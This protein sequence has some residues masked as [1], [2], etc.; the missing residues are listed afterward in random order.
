MVNQNVSA[1]VFEQV[2]VTGMGSGSVVVPEGLAGAVF[3]CLTTYAGWL[4]MNDLTSYGT[5][6][7]PTEI[8]IS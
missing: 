1:P 2:T 7:G 3:A 5:L 8:L 6:A 4:T